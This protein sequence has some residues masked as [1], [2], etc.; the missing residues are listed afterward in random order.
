MVMA[1]SSVVLLRKPAHGGLDSIAGFGLRAHGR[2]LWSFAYYHSAWKLP[3]SGT[4]SAPGKGLEVSG[5]G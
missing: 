2:I 3:V 4:D 5:V 1:E